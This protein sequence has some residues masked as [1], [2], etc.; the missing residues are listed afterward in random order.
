[1]HETSLA[2]SMRQV[3]DGWRWSVYDEDGVRVAAGADT[4]RGRA[5]AA[6]ERMVFAHVGPRARPWGALPVTVAGA[7]AK[8]A[9]MA[10]PKT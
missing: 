6:V 5:Q 8:S 3:E 7:A 4:C 9:E 2:Y 10:E 1:M